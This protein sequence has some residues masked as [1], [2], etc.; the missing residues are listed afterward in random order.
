M[1]LINSIKKNKSPEVNSNKFC[2]IKNSAAPPRSY[3]VL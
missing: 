2:R 1:N 3:V